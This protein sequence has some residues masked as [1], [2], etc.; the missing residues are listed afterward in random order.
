[1]SE[2]PVIAVPY[3]RAPT[4]E[5]TKYYF[6]AL[7]AAGAEHVIVEGEALPSEARGL[8]LTGG[9]DVDPALYGEERDARTDKPHAERDAHEMGL[10][11]QALERDLPVLC[12]CRGH[13][14][15]NV[16]MGG[17]LVQHIDG[18]GH[19]WHDDGGSRWHEVTVESEGRLASAYGAGSVLRVNSRHHQGVRPE[20]LAEGLR[21]TAHSPDGFVE[22]MEGVAQRWL[23]GIQWHPERP[24]EE[25]GETAGP[26]WKAFVGAC[27]GR[28]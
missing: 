13:E 2:R 9:V 1:M 5:R 17:S 25:M 3:W 28:G 26:L 16:A 19:R 27:G 11:R 14:L 18:D 23:V 4:W 21:A 6:D 12:I 7:A 10:L 22:A 8:L 24:D 15:L 20:G